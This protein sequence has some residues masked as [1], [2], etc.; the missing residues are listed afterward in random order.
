MKSH[1]S[2]KGA[3]VDIHPIFLLTRRRDACILKLLRGYRFAC[4]SEE[5]EAQTVLTDCLGF[6]FIA[7][8]RRFGGAINI[9]GEGIIGG[10][11]QTPGREAPAPP[12]KCQ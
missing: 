9:E 7:P 2:T 3:D 10:H 8:P 12:S 4:N 6:L 1:P 5:T 11:P